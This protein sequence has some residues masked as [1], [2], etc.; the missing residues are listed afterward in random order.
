MSTDAFRGGVTYPLCDL[1]PAEQRRRGQ[2][3]NGIREHPESEIPACCVRSGAGV[4]HL[5]HLLRRGLLRRRPP[6]ARLQPDDSSSQGE[7]VSDYPL[8][9]P[10]PLYPGYGVGG[11]IHPRPVS[12]LGH[13][14]HRHSRQCRHGGKGQQKGQAD[15]RPGQRVVFGGPVRK[16]PHGF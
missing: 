11:E 6:A 12:H 7:T 3:Q 10:I 16:Y 1:Y 13:P 8:Q 4:G 2:I 5:P 14:V 9:K 15:Q